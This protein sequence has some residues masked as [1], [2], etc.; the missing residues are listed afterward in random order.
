MTPPP[1]RC[2]ADKGRR[3]EQEEGGAAAQDRGDQDEAAERK[4]RAQLALFA[5]HGHKVGGVTVA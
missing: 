3:A 1:S 4:D 2:Q 5:S